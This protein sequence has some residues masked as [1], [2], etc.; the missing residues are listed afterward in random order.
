MR[1]EFTQYRRSDGLLCFVAPSGQVYEVRPVG[2]PAAVLARAAG[3]GYLTRLTS[4]PSPSGVAGA[5][6]GKADRLS[7]GP[8]RHRALALVP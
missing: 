2:L 5:T 8:R 1:Q 4:E 6:A 7:R 3:D